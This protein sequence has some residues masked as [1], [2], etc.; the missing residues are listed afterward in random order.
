[1]TV[2]FPR[3]AVQDL[4]LRFDETLHANED[5]EYVVRC[6][7]VLGVVSVREITSVYRWWLHTASSRDLHPEEQW[8][9]ARARIQEVVADSVV[10]LQPEEVHRLVEGWNAESR[11]AAGKISGVGLAHA[12]TI[13]C[14]A[15]RAIHSGRMMSGP[16][17]ENAMQTSAPSSASAIPPLRSLPF[18]DRHVSRSGQ[19]APHPGTM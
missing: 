15:M 16:G 13:A 11:A 9:E 12:K 3:G 8:D 1:M 10:L 17:S 6:A 5:W 18:D 19:R 7:A 2:A 14:G 4:G